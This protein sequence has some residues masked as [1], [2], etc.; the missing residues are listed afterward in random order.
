MRAVTTDVNGSDGEESVRDQADALLGEA[1]LN[2]DLAIFVADQD[3][4]YVAANDCACR[5]VGYDREELLAMRVTDLAVAAGSDVLYTQMVEVGQAFGTTVLGA[6]DGS[7]VMFSYWATKT[8][9]RGM[10]LYISVGLR[11]KPRNAH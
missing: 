5:L 3:M 11:G 7:L 8:Y 1:A 2:C 9:A 6:K 4:R 10:P